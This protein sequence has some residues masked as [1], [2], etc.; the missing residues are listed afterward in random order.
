M[1]RNCL[2]ALAGAWS[3]QLLP[4]LPPAGMLAAACVLAAVAICFRALRPAGFFLIGA[5]LIG[6]AAHD[7]IADRLPAER[8]GG[9]VTVVGRVL[10][11]TDARANPVRFL[12]ATED[13]RE[14][15]ARIRLS[16]YDPPSVP[17]IGETW[18]LQARLRRPRGFSNPLRF[19]YEHWLFRQ[20]IGATGYVVAGPEN[21]R[22]TDVRVDRLSALRQALV[23]RMIALLG[24]DPATAV[25]LAI[26]V[27]ATH[28]IGRTE[29]ERYA[30]SGTSHLMAISG[31]NIAMAAGGAAVLA[32]L[33]I[34][35]F[36][37][38]ANVRDLAAMVAVV[39][40]IA[41]SE[42]SG[43]AIPVRRAMLMAL[44]L[45][46]AS[47]LRRQLR[48][49]RLLAA[50]CIAIVASD[51]LA[52]HAPGFKLSF[53][54]VAILLWAARQYGLATAG[55]PVAR[56]LAAG[57]LNLMALQV[58]LL[59]GLF[60]LTALLFGRAAW[61]A[62]MVNML[63]LPLFNLVTVPAGL[64]GLL[65]GG[66]LRMLGDGLL[67][68]AWYSVRL[69][70]WVVDAVAGWGPAHTHIATIGGAMLLVVWLPAVW[71]VAPPGFPGRRLAWI[72][73]VAI[74]LHRAPPPPPRC[75]DLTALD[76]GQGLSVVLRTH[77]R[78][79][80]YDTGPSFRSGSDTGALV[81]VPYLRALGV[82]RIDLLM[83]SHADADHAGGV[84]SVLED[85]HVTELFAGEYLT[86]VPYEQ[87]VCRQG[88]AWT[89]DGVRFAI[90]HPGV[91]PVTTGN[92]A[93]CVL[94]V[95]VGRHSILLTGDIESA[96]E[97]HLVRTRVLTPTDLVVVP[98]HGSR[99]SSSATFVQTL[100]PS[101]AIVSAGYDNRW[102]LPKDDVVARWQSAGARV[103][104]TATS[105]AIH[106]RICPDTGAVLQSEN[107]KANLEYWHEP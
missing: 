31:M 23:D 38:R 10:D 81:V 70:L 7:L 92:D 13:A 76:V 16:W 83:A 89:W 101:A 77:R 75:I 12:L 58:T 84:G 63:V 100:R 96:V 20:G 25:L 34:A 107:R 48:A 9:T 40:A 28:E 41:Y 91:Y 36:C 2:G 60:P 61:L 5:S 17:R 14:V 55:V 103:L 15:P 90:M 21:A 87:R 1:L 82:R 50:T 67:T 79:L 71:A 51:P 95:G 42:I 18:T 93:S 44:L 62:P 98:H 54:A 6:F 32:W 104:N 43:F 39:A 27:G 52:L 35:P 53:A 105:G 45:L 24:R 106:Y 66:P 86:G 22:R 49:T 85:M 56:R 59:F 73:A 65:C 74:V 72:A 11:F 78:T 102:G 68:I 26:T 69:M 30:V 4:R 80:V 57:A 97:A 99:T 37:R 88:Q 47:L 29:W 19:D 94:E 46:A 33:L 3:L 8:E 64:L